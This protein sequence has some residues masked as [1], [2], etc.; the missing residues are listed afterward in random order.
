MCISNSIR[1]SRILHRPQKRKRQRKPTAPFITSRLQQDA[2][3]ALRFSAKKTM[4]MAQSLYQGKDLEGDE[5]VGLITYMRTDSTRISDDALA[6]VRTYIGNSFGTEYLP[7][8]P[9]IYKTKCLVFIDN[10]EYL[11][12]MLHV[13]K[14]II[15]I[16][17]ESLVVS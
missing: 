10:V 15:I 9:N 12:K 16:I 5:T 7:K 8:S 1:F 17:P 14:H 2:A 6:E 4:A 11:L 13:I 3:R